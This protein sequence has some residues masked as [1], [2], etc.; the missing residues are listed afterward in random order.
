MRWLIIIHLVFIH[1]LSVP[2]TNSIVIIRTDSSES[3]PIEL[4]TGF[5][6]LLSAELNPDIQTPGVTLNQDATTSSNDCLFGNLDSAKQIQ[7]RQSPSPE[8]TSSDHAIEEP[9]IS[10]SIPVSLESGL[11]K[12]EDEMAEGKACTVPQAE[13]PPGVRRLPGTN[14][15]IDFWRDHAPIPKTGSPPPD[16]EEFP[17]PE[18]I[19][20]FRD[21]PVCDSGRESDIQVQAIHGIDIDYKL[22]RITLPILGTY[23]HV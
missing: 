19:F 13:E 7:R 17:C 9:G 6:T 21:I 11:L 15:V 23:S 22:L 2:F 10:A 4:D 16:L 18:S 12:T 8:S 20:H 3:E 1:M 5:E 14:D